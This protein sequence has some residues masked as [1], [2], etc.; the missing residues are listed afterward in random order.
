MAYQAH[1]ISHDHGITREVYEA[2]HIYAE[3]VQ[4][5][6][7][8]GT[9]EDS[10][11]EDF[12]RSAMRLYAGVLCDPNALAHMSDAMRRETLC[13]LATTVLRWA[14]KVRIGTPPGIP[15]PVM[16]EGGLPDDPE[17]D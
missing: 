2:T 9:D 14:R 3:I 16:T 6:K 1:D 11:S 8:I 10:I 17:H 12:Y 13:A 5:L 7:S 4:R 15:S